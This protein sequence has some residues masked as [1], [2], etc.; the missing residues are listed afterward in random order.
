[1]VKVLILFLIRISLGLKR[2]QRFQ[3]DNQ[4][5]E[6]DWYYIEDDGIYKLFY[7]DRDNL[8]I[9]HSNVSLNWLLDSRCKI[10]KK[11]VYQ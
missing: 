9:A 7:D 1:M 4:S 5:N 10:I 11:E 6:L 8:R 3:F 2:G